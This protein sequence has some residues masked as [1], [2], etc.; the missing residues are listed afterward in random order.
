LL[1]KL[2]RSKPALAGDEFEVAIWGAGPNDKV[3]KQGVLLNRARKFS[4]VMKVSP[5]LVGAWLESVER[6]ELKRVHGSLT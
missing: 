6:N 4:D 2:K 5:D 3:L 1:Q